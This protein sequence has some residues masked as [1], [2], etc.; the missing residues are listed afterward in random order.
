MRGLEA[1]QK[2][3]SPS[4]YYNH[5]TLCDLVIGG[6]VGLVPRDDR[7]VQ[8]EPLLPAERWD[9]FCLD[10]VLYHG[11]ILTI[12]WDRNGDKYDKGKGL[13]VF[14]DGIEIVGASELTRVTEEL[15]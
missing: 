11:H 5:S 14:A 3:P 10:N 9:W 1:K 15:P 4:R 7:V 13:R 6:L 2:R 12:L 8:V